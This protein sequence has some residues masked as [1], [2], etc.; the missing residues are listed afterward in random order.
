MIND[1]IIEAMGA[2]LDMCGSRQQELGMQSIFDMLCDL[3]EKEFAAMDQAERD[4]WLA[5]YL[6]CK[7][8]GGAK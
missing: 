4:E 1:I 6:L 8:K 5:R 3:N 7:R 2:M